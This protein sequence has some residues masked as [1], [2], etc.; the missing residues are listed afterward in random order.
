MKT[1][2]IFSQNSPQLVRGTLPFAA[3]AAAV[4]A[5][6]RNQPLS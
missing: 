3:A 6:G 1:P 2:K 5:S 4:K